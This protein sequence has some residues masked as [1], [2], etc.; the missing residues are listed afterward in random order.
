M[1]KTKYSPNPI[2]NINANWGEDLNDTDRRP[3]SG[4]AVQNFIKSELG[5]KVGYRYEDYENDRYLYFSS[6]EDCDLYLSDPENYS[7]L[8]MWVGEMQKAYTAEIYLSSAPVVNIK[9]GQSGNYIDFT[10]DVKNRQGGS[11][12]DSAIVTY[13]FT[14]DSGSSQN[15]TEIYNNGTSVHFKVDDYLVDGTNRIQVALKGRTTLA[16]TTQSIIYNVIAFD[17]YSEFDNTQV[18][19]PDQEFSFN[20]RATGVGTKYYN[21]YLD[22]DDITS[23]DDYIT[24]LSGIRSKVVHLPDDIT[25]GKHAIK[26]QGYTSAGGSNFYSD[27]IYS[28]FVVSGGVNGI[29][30]FNVSLDSTLSAVKVRQYESVEIGYSVYDPRNRELAL[31]VTDGTDVFVNRSI[32]SGV[33]SSFTYTPLNYG[34]LTITAEFDGGTFTLPVVSEQSSVSMSKATDGL[35]LEFSAKGRTNS[36]ISKEEWV[37]GSYRAVLEGVAFNA[38]SGWSGDALVLSGGAKVTIPYAPLSEN[39]ASTGRTIEID[40]SVD[41]GNKDDSAVIMDI[42]DSTT[43]VGVY[44]TPTGVHVKATD[45]SSFNHLTMTGSRKKMAII[46]NRNTIDLNHNIVYTVVNGKIGYSL[47]YTASNPFPCNKNI[48]IGDTSGSCTIRLYGIRVYNRALSIE[49]ALANYAIESGKVLEV[50][51]NNDIFQTGTNRLSFDKTK[52]KVPSMRIIG[53]I[54]KLLAVQDKTTTIQAVVEFYDPNNVNSYWKADNVTIKNQGTSTLKFPVKNFSFN[55]KSSTYYDIL[56]NVIQ[57]K[58]GIQ[59]R[60]NSATVKK[61]VAKCDFMESSCSFNT[62]GAISFNDTGYKTQVDGQ[63]V[64]RTLAQRYAVQQGITTDIRTAIDGLPIAMFY[65][66]TA[67]ED[68]ICLG[69]YNLNNGKDD[70]PEAYGFSGLTGYDTSNT[71]RWELAEEDGLCTFTAAS[72]TDFDANYGNYFECVFPAEDHSPAKLKRLVGWLAAC[73]NN[74]AK[75]NSEYENYLDPWKCA[76]YYIHIFV[77]NIGVDQVAKN[78]HLVTEDGLHWFPVYYDGDSAKLNDNDGYQFDK[79]YDENGNEINPLY[80]DRQSTDKDGNYVFQA[81]DSVLWNCIENSP[82]FQTIIK[83]SIAA[84][85]SAGLNYETEV[86][87][88]ITKHTAVFPERVVN[89]TAEAKYFD[90]FR[91]GKANYLYVCQGTKDDRIKLIADRRL[92]R[93]EA[94]WGFGGY[95]SRA[96]NFRLITGN[97]VANGKIKIKAFSDYWFAY[98][99]NLNMVESGVRLEANETYQFTVGSH[100]N[101]D[102]LRIH[103]TDQMSEL[104]MS[105]LIEGLYSLEVGAS[106]SEESTTH[107]KKL[108]L[109]DGEHTNSVLSDIRE[110]NKLVALEYLDIRGLSGITSIASLPLLNTLLAEGSSLAVFRPAEGST[111]SVVTLPSTITDLDIRDCNF[112]T[113][114][115]TPGTALNN[116]RINRTTGINTKNLI[117]AWITALNGDSEKLAQAQLNVDNINWTLDATTLF[118][119]LTIETVNLKG[120][121]VLTDTMTFEL[122][123]Q[124]VDVFGPTCFNPE[125]TLYID[126]VDTVLIR[127]SKT[128][129][130]SGNGETITFTTLP[131]P[132]SADPV[133]F[134][135]YNENDQKLTPNLSGIATWKGAS[136]NTQT[137]VITTTDYSTD[138]YVSVVAKIS[139][140][141][142][143]TPV[144]INVTKTIRATDLSVTGNSTLNT[145]TDYHYSVS[146]LPANTTESIESITVNINKIIIPLTGFTIT[147]PETISATGTYDYTTTFL[148]STSN[149]KVTGMNALPTNLPTGVTVVNVN[150]HGF[151]LQVDSIPST[152]V[153]GSV[154]LTATTEQGNLEQTTNITFKIPVSS[155]SLS[156]A[157]TILAINGSG[158]ENYI[159]TYNPA[160]YTVPVTLVSVTSSNQDFTISSTS[161]SGFSV[162][163]S[164]VS[165]D[166]TTTVT[167]ILSID[168][169]ETTLTKSLTAHYSKAV[170]THTVGEI[171]CS[172]GS[173]ITPTI[174]WETGECTNID[175]GGKTPIGIVVV[176][177][178]HTPDGTARIM[179][180]LECDLT[181]PSTPTTTHNTMYW[182][183]Y[184]T[185]TSLTNYTTVPK[186]D[187]STD[188]SGYTGTKWS[189]NSMTTSE[190]G[191]YYYNGSNKLKSPYLSD[192]VSQDT[193][194]LVGA[195]SDFDGKG[196]TDTLIS[197]ATSDTNWR[198]GSI[199]DS[200]SSGYYPA[201]CA[202]YRYITP[203]TQ[204]GDWYLPACRELVYVVYYLKLFNSILSKLKT[205]NSGSAVEMDTNTSYWSSSEYSDL[206]SYSVR[207]NHGYVANYTKSINRRVR[208]FLAV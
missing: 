151:Q 60:E 126:T 153:T 106:Y 64:M 49:E 31:R 136:L 174:N 4:E 112:T 137:G 5:K 114:T 173:Y 144:V 207:M 156:G 148:P 131:V 65:Q 88:Y 29:V 187:G 27:I 120:R 100:A 203:G 184:G 139:E 84:E 14:S 58:K 10:F 85:Y 75:F 189:Y 37:S 40:Y 38:Q 71:E 55:F 201:A 2:P 45:N 62:A 25:P 99:S 170:N 15:V 202:C 33:S 79:A 150:K 176:P 48:V 23:V 115:F 117:L 154:K 158:T 134:D 92:K 73:E 171:Y 195:M 205:L 186:L 178:S 91:T 206:N 128:T 132:D 123:N 59:L 36:D 87:T 149:I 157:D 188:S 119:I 42:A 162:S 138:F 80:V 166:I 69:Q 130:K 182:G 122:Y 105:E 98:S 155:V 116:V 167:A 145:I 113:F 161:T 16:S 44:M 124:L 147:G 35:V 32:V 41:N 208:P 143:S 110:L 179:S 93:Y 78:M 204:E 43:K 61:L 17:I 142:Q 95:A 9:S 181:N 89:Q 77:K 7:E 185:D 81:H 74:Q 22:E 118:S 66:Q 169:T 164:G 108:V 50:A 127:A 68:E 47:N 194:S 190:S 140:S 172:D 57:G 135:L 180:L 177:G 30:L 104:D 21:V 133:T 97:T 34:E 111:Y 1:A 90:A 200:Y 193:S 28:E 26:I 19:E 192:G 52:L 24:S 46:F 152:V 199:T 20:I 12:G 53:N 121:I 183:G 8:L 146:P 39:I 86:E 72:F 11:S 103:A 196:N 191:L 125:S 3:Y 109:G 159:F 163:V 70:C 197:L 141:V 165:T 107:L 6:A 13:T 18:Y 198:T 54:Q 56:G 76:H 129:V 94:L 175:L 96:I 101:G 63:Y 102:I 82:A 168:G 67:R 83:K 160:N 51:S